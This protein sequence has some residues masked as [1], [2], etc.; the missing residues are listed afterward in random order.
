ML[1][2]S[3]LTTIFLPILGI[4]GDGVC[5]LPQ[6]AVAIHVILTFLPAGAWLKG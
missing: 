4:D 5:S 2:Y 3:H 1:C 6:L